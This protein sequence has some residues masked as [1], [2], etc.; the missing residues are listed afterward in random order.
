MAA[1]SPDRQPTFS[2]DEAAL[3][4]W[5]SDFGGD[6]PATVASMCEH[7]TEAAEWMSLAS[8]EWLRAG[9]D[10]A[11]L[12]VYA[13]HG[14]DGGF[15][16]TVRHTSWPYG[17]HGFQLATMH[18]DSGD[19]SYA[20]DDDDPVAFAQALV[21]IA[22][23]LVDLVAGEAAQYMLTKSDLATLRGWTTSRRS[24]FGQWAEQRGYD[25]PES[26]YWLDH[27][28]A[29]LDWECNYGRAEWEEGAANDAEGFAKAII[30]AIDT[31]SLGSTLGQ[32]AVQ[33]LVGELSPVVPCQGG[34]RDHWASDPDHA[35]ET[36]VDEVQSNSTRLGYWQWVANQ[37]EADEGTPFESY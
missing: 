26:G 22:N 18:I 37:R 2:I 34:G 14:S 35:W 10:G 29:Y 24:T 12:Q 7:A 27:D 5:W 28:A 6:E 25:W 36:W 21:D 8:S 16:L 11:Q 20:F 4:A 9:D 17:H 13:L 31:R 33:H 32:H 3:R 15:I 30:A 1:R 23:N 19:M